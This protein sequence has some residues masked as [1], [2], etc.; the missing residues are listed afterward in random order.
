MAQLKYLDLANSLR[1][2]ILNGKYNEG[3]KLPSENELS[4]KHGFSRQTVRQAMDTLDKEGILERKQGSGTYVVFRENDKRE[5]T[6][7][8]G[9]ISTYTDSY[10][11]PAIINGIDSVLR[12]K[13][14]MMQ[15]SLTHNQVENE[16][17]VLRMFLE[18]DV[19]G[20][21]VEPT[22]S[23]LPN[24]NRALYSQIKQRNIPLVF[25]N[26]YYPNLSFQHVCMNDR[27]AG[28]KAAR[29]LIDAGHK[30]IA[31]I[32]KADDRQ[33][34]LR[35]IGFMEALNEAGLHTKSTRIIWFVTEDM[36]Y[37]AED[38]ARIKRG[39]SDCTGL[40]C[41]NDQ[42]AFTI[43]PALIREGYAI[44][45]DL[46]VVGIDNAELAAFCE[47]P[48]TSLAHPMD[49][50][51]QA[52]ARGILKLIQNPEEQITTEFEPELVIRDSV[53]NLT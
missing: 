46:S 11:F 7:N 35:Y 1:S 20:L 3:Q 39:L 30:I 44:P 43:V 22:K 52:A 51:G 47:V 36:P 12:E 33:G 13:G 48:L 15:L 5:P 37:L 2:D 41:Y 32:F 29:C 24:I 27:L 42:I 23:G 4:Q 9:I 6:K 53:K 16:A 31:G 40:V 17:Q 28:Y 14:Y 38:I 45:D 8:V 10:I 50:L 26:T 21:I 18:K 25:F 49:K 34:Q 19:D